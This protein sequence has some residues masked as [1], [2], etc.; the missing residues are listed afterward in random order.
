VFGGGRSRADIGAQG[1]FRVAQPAILLQQPQDLHIDPI[2]LLPGGRF[3]GFRWISGVHRS[4][5]SHFQRF[6]RHCS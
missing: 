3:F 5:Y 6:R 1:K 2:E 4:G